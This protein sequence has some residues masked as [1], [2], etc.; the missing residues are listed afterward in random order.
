[1][2]ILASREQFTLHEVASCGCYLKLSAHSVF[3][4]KAL[5]SHKNATV[6]QEMGG[7]YPSPISY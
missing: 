5:K 7:D 1:M 4:V 6:M 3:Q 2:G